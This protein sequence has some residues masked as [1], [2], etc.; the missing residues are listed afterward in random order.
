MLIDA[1]QAVAG[2]A[3]NNYAQVL[4]MQLVCPKVDMQSIGPKQASKVYAL[5]KHAISMPDFEC[6]AHTL[7]KLQSAGP[8]DASKAYARGS[9]CKLHARNKQANR[10][11]ELS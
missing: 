6:K 9:R 11:P 4:C 10:M 5:L 1:R 3:S 2:D 8:I 7:I